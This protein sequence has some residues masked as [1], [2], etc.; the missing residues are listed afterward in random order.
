MHLRYAGGWHGPAQIVAIL[1][2]AVAGGMAGSQLVILLRRNE[3]DVKRALELADLVGQI[4]AFP[5]G[6][7]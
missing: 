1:L 3:P 5:A 2:V 6:T 7:S 4:V